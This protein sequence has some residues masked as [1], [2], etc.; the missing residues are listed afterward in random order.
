MNGNFTPLFN[1][2]A[3][4]NNYLELT[5]TAAAGMLSAQSNSGEI[6]VTI[7]SNDCMLEK[8]TMMAFDHLG[9]YVCLAVALWGLLSV[10]V[11]IHNDGIAHPVVRQH[12]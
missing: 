1:P 11:S 9:L 12:S 7:R 4:A 10:L 3:T 2:V 6:A 8:L 5:F